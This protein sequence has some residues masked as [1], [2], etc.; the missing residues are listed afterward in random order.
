MRELVNWKGTKKVTQNR[1]QKYGEN[2]KDMGK[3]GEKLWG[4][5]WGAPVEEAFIEFTEGKLG[6]KKYWK[7]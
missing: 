2:G 4:I 7:R 5:E 6:Q 1:E 3:T